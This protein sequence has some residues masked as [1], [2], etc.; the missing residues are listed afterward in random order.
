MK[1]N[2]LEV[3]SMSLVGGLMLLGIAIVVC[4]LFPPLLIIV[5]PIVYM[6]LFSH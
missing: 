5:G 2:K 6:I 4:L 1:T 3:L